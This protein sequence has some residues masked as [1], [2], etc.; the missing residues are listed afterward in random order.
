MKR[1]IGS[2]GAKMKEIVARSG[3]DAKLRL[4]GKGS[5]FVERDL[6]V[7]SP[8]PLQLCISC[9]TEAGYETAVRCSK[10]LLRS[11]YDEYNEWCGERGSPN[12]A[13]EIHMTEKHHDGHG[14][15]DGGGGRRG[16][17]GN[18][19]KSPPRQRKGTQR[20]PTHSIAD[21]PSDASQ[22]PANAPPVEEIKRLISDRND[23]RRRGEFQEA[24]RIRADLKDRG[25]VL[26]DEKG[27]HGS[28]QHV[29]SWRYW[30]D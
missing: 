2:G 13:P 5:G 1:I 25:V 28:A 9:P 30:T 10:E 20:L 26:S 8:E 22:P 4:R 18:R 19:G 12:K 16:R 11:V 15:G 21:A 14:A 29:T 17:G 7:E 24:D 23:A 27:R 3:G 6:K